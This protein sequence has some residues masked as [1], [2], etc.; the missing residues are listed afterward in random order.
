MNSEGVIINGSTDISSTSGL[1]LGGAFCLERPDRGP[2]DEV[3]EFVASVA[4]TTL[5]RR[6]IIKVA[7]IKIMIRNPIE[8]PIIPPIIGVVIP[9]VPLFEAPVASVFAIGTADEGSLGIKPSLEDTVAVG[10]TG[11]V[12]VTLVLVTVTGFELASVVVIVSSK[13]KVEIL[14]A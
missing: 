5:F 6:R 14:V 12:A 11:V 8:P 3:R 2:L 1:R 9:V 7:T 13:V 10:V 4:L